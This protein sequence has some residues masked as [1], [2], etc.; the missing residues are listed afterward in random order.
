MTEGNREFQALY[1]KLRIVDQKKY[2]YDRCKEYEAAHR[3]EVP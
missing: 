1:H 3:R 2:Y